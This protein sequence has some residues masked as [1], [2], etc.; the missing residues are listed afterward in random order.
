MAYS[1]Q[2]DVI[3]AVD[4]VARISSFAQANGWQQ[5]NIPP[6]GAYDYVVLRKNGVTDVVHIFNTDGDGASDPAPR[7][8][9]RAS[10]GY[11]SLLPLAQQ[12][13]VTPS[14]T[15]TNALQGPFPTVWMFASGDEIN[16][17][18]RRSDVN[19]A[20]A[21][22]AFGRIQKYGDYVGG[23]FVDGS[24][25]STTG[26]QSGRW[27]ESSD[28]ALWGYGVASQN[29]VQGF[30]RA[31]SVEDGLVSQ[32]HR[33][34]HNSGGIGNTLFNAGTGV[35][36]A[37]SGDVF[38]GSTYTYH[39]PE[40]ALVF[41][42]DDNTFSGR[43]VFQPIEVSVR[44]AGTPIYFSPI[45]YSAACRFAS[46]AKYDPEQE[47]TVAGETWM[48]FPVARKAAPSDGQNAPIGTD[49]AGF[50]IRKVV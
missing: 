26:F 31:D 40:A 12:P 47:V 48:M 28:S 13:G 23:T 6:R 2:S 45:G 37:Q 14:N 34:A 49:N 10:T 30:V 46:L 7:I 35:G 3:S 20:Y 24:F 21:H 22:M 39:H 50:A 11:D 8:A 17:V 4:L 19:G 33:I 15:L 43:S 41:G 36:P 18:V 44:R 25:F 38:T 32:W 9:M 27:E 42:A 29:Y 5:I 16:I 1:V